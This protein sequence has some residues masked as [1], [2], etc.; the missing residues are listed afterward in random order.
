[1]AGKE[2][3]K[4][5]LDICPKIVTLSLDYYNFIQREQAMR[6]NVAYKFHNLDGSIINK[7]PNQPLDLKEVILSALVAPAQEPN[8]L[9]VKK[10]KLAQ[11]AFASQTILDISLEQAKLIQDSLP[12]DLSAVIFGQAVEVLE[13]NEPHWP[14]EY[15]EIKPSTEDDKEVVSE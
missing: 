10:Y 12:K 6:I 15:Q 2:P 9:K 1:M 14:D 5:Y 13:G 11:K 4:N 8:E 7:A 3:G